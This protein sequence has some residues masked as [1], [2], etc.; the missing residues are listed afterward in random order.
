MK[1]YVSQIRSYSDLSL[2]V[3]LEVNEVTKRIRLRGERKMDNIFDIGLS[4]DGSY[5]VLVEWQGL[6]FLWEVVSKIRDDA[7]KFPGG[8]LKRTK[9]LA[10]VQKELRSLRGMRLR[11]MFNAWHLFH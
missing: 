2:D 3:A 8:K 9:L 5:S 4:Y 11:W 10:S 6:G 7:P 1:T